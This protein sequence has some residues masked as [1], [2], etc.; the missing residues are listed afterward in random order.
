MKRDAQKA[1]L[2]A[3]GRYIR[4]LVGPIEPRLKAVEDGLAGVPLLLERG[5]MNIPAPRDGKD[6][7]PALIAKAVA[8]AVAAIPA[9]KD[10][11]CVTI[12]DVRP[13]VED[14][15]KA[16]PKPQDGRDG[17]TP[18]QVREMVAE[19]IKALPPAK[20]GESVTV[21]QVLA[22]LAPAMDAAIAKAVLDVERRAQGVL[23]RAVAN[24]PKPKD[25]KD[26]VDGFSLDDLQIDDDGDGTMTLRFV[27]GELVRE[28]SIRYPRGDRGIYREEGDYR[29]GDGTTYGGSF[30]IAQKDAP[31][32]RPGNSADW[33]L[34]V[35]AGRDGPSAYQV[36][37]RNGFKG[38]EKDWVERGG[39]LPLPVVKVN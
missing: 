36:A 8:E 4:K 34:A 35:K 6:A 22:E 27:R 21:E 5:M 29:K 28:K 14:A 32:G 38:S 16:I 23:E 31:E 24:I 30:W 15:V 2:A 10:G 1:L 17:A 26:G 9:P 25:G 13:L 37:L 12:E 18:E 33:R 11:T 3:A 20:D 7:D 19:A 39:P